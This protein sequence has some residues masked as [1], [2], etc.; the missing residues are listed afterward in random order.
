[1]KETANDSSSFFKFLLGMTK[2][3]GDFKGLQLYHVE[4]HCEATPHHQ[5]SGHV[6]VLGPPIYIHS[7]LDPPV[8]ESTLPPSVLDF[9]E[10]VKTFPFI[11]ITQTLQVREETPQY[12]TTKTAWFEWLE[13]DSSKPNP[14]EQWSKFDAVKIL[15]R[16]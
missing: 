16:F 15:A 6:G 10:R 7:T 9:Y 4:F 5:T 2:M 3:L 14:E 11:R 12:T 1:M 8:D 13:K